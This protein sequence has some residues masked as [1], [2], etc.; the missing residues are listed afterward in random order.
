MNDNTLRVL[1]GWKEIAAYLNCSRSTAVRRVE[2][3]LPVFRVGGNVR[4]FAADLDRWLEGER[5]RELEAAVEKDPDPPG[6]IV[7]GAA[8]AETAASFARDKENLRYALIPLGIDTSEY[9]RIEGRLKTAEEKYRW[10]LETVPAWIWETDEGG[11]FTYS[12]VAV[13]DILD[14]RPEELAGFK[15]TEFLIPEEEAKLFDREI[16]TLRKRKKLIRDFKCRFTRRDGGLRWL[17]TDA[18]PVFDAAGKFAGVRGVS[19]DITE[20]HRAEEKEQ[21]HLRNL[22]FLSETAMAFVELAPQADLLSYITEKVRELAG[23]AVVAIAAYDEEA[24]TFRFQELLGL[25]KKLGVFPK[26]LG[27]GP[28]ELVFPTS[29]ET[30]ASLLRGKLEK[31]SGDIEELTGGVIGGAVARKFKKALG[32]GDIYAMGIV[33]RGTLLGAVGVI[34]PPG[35]EL[36]PRDTIE[37]FVNQAAVAFQRRRAEEAQRESEEKYRD[38]VD[39][40]M[41]GLHIIQDHV[42]KFCNQRFAEILGYDS[43]QELIGV[44][45]DELVAPD[46]REFIAEELKLRLAG[47]R[48]ADQIVCKVVKKDGTIIDAAGLGSRIT[49]EGRP[50]IHGGLQDI[51]DRIRAERARERERTAFRIIAEAAVEAA[52]TRGLC[53]RVLQGLAEALAFD[54]GTVELFDADRGFLYNCGAAGLTKKQIAVKETPVPLD[55]DRHVSAYVGRTREALFVPDLRDHPVNKTYGPWLKDLDIRGFIS[56]PLLGGEGQL[57]GVLQLGGRTPKVLV[58]GDQTFFA[59][60]AGMFAT[61]LERRRAEEA[62][63]ESEEKFRDVVERANDGIAIVKDGRFIYVNPRIVEATGYAA[64]ELLEQPFTTFIDPDEIPKVSAYHENRVKGEEAPTVY[65]TIVRRKDGSKLYVEANVGTFRYRGEPAVLALIRDLTERKRAQELTHLQRELAQALAAPISLEEAGRLCV[66]AALQA[67][68]MDSGGLYAAEVRAG[69]GELVYHEGLGEAFVEAVSRFDVASPQARLVLEGKPLFATYEDLGVPLTEVQV[70]EGLK[71]VGVIPITFE[72]D[73]VACLNVA[74]HTAEAIEPWAQEGLKAIA[75]QVG[76]ALARIRTEEA[77]TRANEEW[78]RT[79]DAVPDM[80]ALIDDQ[81]RLLRVNE[82]TARRAGLTPQECVGRNCYTLFHGTEEPPAFCPHAKLMKDGREHEAEFYEKHLGAHLVVT[83]SPIRDAEGQLAG[84]VHVARD[85]T[86]RVQ[87]EEA[88]ERERKAFRIIAEAAVKG[89]DTRSLCRHVVAGLAQAL[90]FEMGTVRLYDE[91]TKTLQKTAFFG[92]TRDEL[93]DYFPAQKIDDPNYLAAHVTRTREAIFAP[94]VSGHKFAKAHRARIKKLGLAS[95]ISWPLLGAD[96][97]LTG[98]MQLLSR[99]PREIPEGDRTFFETVAGMFTTVLERRRAEET[100]RHSEAKHRLLLESIGS[101]VL[102]L[103][104]K[105]N[106]MYHNEAY[107]AFV[108]RPREEIEGENLLEILPSF[109]E[110]ETHGAFARALATDTPQEA[111]GEFGE[112]YFRTNVF[113]MPWGIL[114]IATDLTERKGAEEALRESEEKF[115]TIIESSPVGM[116]LYELGAE[117][118]L[119]F[120]GGNPAADEILGLDNSQFVGKALEEAFPSAADTEIPE[121]YRRA[122]AEGERWY[123]E[124]IDYEDEQIKGAFAVQ[125]FQTSPGKMVAA[126]SDITER[127]RAEEALR[128]SEEKYRATV[129]QA[130]DGIIIVADGKLAFVNDYYATLLGYAKDDLIGRSIYDMVPP[131]LREGFAAMYELALEHGVTPEPVDAYLLTADGREIPAETVSA[132]ITYDG[133]PAILVTIR[134]VSER[135]RAEKALRESEEKFRNLAE[136]SP[137]MIFINFRGRVVYANAKCEQVMGYTREEFYAPDFDFLTLIEPASRELVQKSFA[138]HSRGEEVEPYEYSLV[139]KDGRQI[140]ALITTTLLPYEG[141]RAILGIVTDVTARKHAMEALRDSEERYRVL[142]EGGNDAVFVFNLTPAGKASPFIEVNNEACRYLGY[143][144][145]ELHRLT[146]ADLVPP[147][148][149]RAVTKKLK[150]LSKEK[151]L[152]FE[153]VHV[154]K[155]GTEIPVEVSAHLFE[156]REKPT[157]ISIVRDITE[158]KNAEEALRESE[159]KY[160][161][162]VEQARDGI[163]IVTEGEYAFANEHFA[164]MSGYAKEELLGRSILELVPERSRE[165]IAARYREGLQHGFTNETVEAV[166]LTRDGREVPVETNPAPIKFEGRSAELIIVRDVTER[167]RAEEALHESE[168][169]FRRLAEDFR[170]AIVIYDQAEDR[171]TYANPA[172]VEMFGVTRHD[173]CGTAFETTLDAFVHDDDL[174]R[175]REANAKAHLARSAGSV[176]ALELDFRAARPD[177]E[178]RWIHQRSYPLLIEGAPSS[179]VCIIYSDVTARL[180]TEGPPEREGDRPAP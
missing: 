117:G 147:E 120:V 84:C 42:I 98:A 37:A 180:R 134:N 29:A 141:G 177:G 94:D 73:I 150:Q 161:E 110:T 114:A 126:F 173:L 47:E 28:F 131:R 156:F 16:G 65:E 96:G 21:E 30:K 168:E 154:K 50:A 136:G 25:E 169:R 46:D 90:G 19:R 145:E 13:V 44:G 75:A 7:E 79:F 85:V 102:A 8:L 123:A 171:V 101:P 12:N 109:A 66:Q 41:V 137:N 38:V 176:E 80:V 63:E 39:N 31:T 9:E 107:A 76:G 179:E 92:L 67:G 14:Y 11:E 144:A 77:L 40:S 125:A 139:T 89:G 33:S 155:D 129:E 165:D 130:R 174:D 15:H 53:Q 140:E 95:I 121:R 172:A 97:R 157:V 24:D 115:R 70:R 58:E 111:E 93:D 86:E 49:Y 164:R 88:R 178:E 34:P 27:K 36:A 71:T 83:T 113:P 106:I 132:D 60:V 170:E 74:S 158:R 87:A 148:T 57:L 128:E 162:F 153:W 56:W 51:T 127:K 104:A 52:E 160:R 103:D 82:A 68:G 166:V 72:G 17:E 138:A 6:I 23:E 91:E 143:S 55:D 124:Q 122:A 78:R 2:D 10:L 159:E 167:K 135:K 22:S 149:K 48:E 151:E 119:V 61:V 54:F 62:L 118:R 18:E 175:L 35:V 69:A 4:A 1:I 81:Y 20:R 116:H 64:E 142:F 146:P 163:V 43:A 133:R 26:L 5:L 108:G 45:V 32:M 112:A 59:T 100:I 105:M 152:V 3:G 99:S